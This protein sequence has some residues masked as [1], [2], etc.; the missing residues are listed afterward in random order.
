MAFGP[1]RAQAWRRLAILGTALLALAGCNSSDMPKE[2]KPVSAALIAKMD[3]LGMKETSPILI[4]IFKE[5]SEL[6]VWKLQ[7]DG[8]YALLKTYQICKWSG[9]LGPKK[10]E[11]D[12]QAPEGFY[13]V[14]P[15]Q[16]N[17]NSS[18]YL[19]FNI[20]YPNAY[21]RSLGRTGAHLMVHGACSSAGCYSMTDE[22]A[23]ELFALARDSF[24]GGQTSFQIQA[25]PFRMTAENFARHVGDANMP[26]WRM[27]KTGYDSFELT[28]TAPKVDVCDKKYVFNAEAGEARF[29]PMRACPTYVVPEKLVAALEQRRIADE[30]RIKQA[31]AKLEDEEKAKKAEEQ[32][33]ATKA[34]ADEKAAAER[35][36]NPGPIARILGAKPGTPAVVAAPVIPAK[37]ADKEPTMAA[38]PKP[39]LKP[40]VKAA[41]PQVETAPPATATVAPAQAADTGKLTPAVTSGIPPVGTFVKKRFDWPDDEAPPA[42]GGKSG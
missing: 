8:E 3:Q 33:A 2:L 42:A 21:D 20:G 36:A 15:A 1:F 39:K 17:P 29:D 5:S 12:R 25:Y 34:V 7:S 31:A 13:T 28:R 10:V 41:I 9:V 23:G 27:L 4:R 19:S 16:M 24:R 30:A 14:T 38:V 11:G 22:D 40:E 37:L 18:Y 32:A 26:F 6:E 35:V